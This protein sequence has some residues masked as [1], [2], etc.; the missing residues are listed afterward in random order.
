MTVIATYTTFRATFATSST[1]DVDGFEVW[2]LA[3]V[4]S[5]GFTGG[6]SGIGKPIQAFPIT[7]S[8]NGGASDASDATTY[9]WW[10]SQRTEDTASQWLSCVHSTVGYSGTVTIALTAKCVTDLGLGST[11]DSLTDDELRRILMHCY[12]YVQRASDD[13]IQWVDL[14]AETQ[15]DL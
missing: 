10:L 11:T 5:G 2:P 6:F 12:L 15:S 1:Q 8:C 3:K 4:R 14:L 13:A 7:V 9:A